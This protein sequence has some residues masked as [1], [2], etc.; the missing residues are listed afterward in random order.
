MAA[1]PGYQPR[2]RFCRDCLVEQERI[3]YFPASN[4]VYDEPFFVGRQV[5]LGKC[6][7]GKNTL[8]KID[9]ILDEGRFYFQPRILDGRDRIAELED[10][11][12]PSLI[13]SEHSLADNNHKDD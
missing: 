8:L 1:A 12:L 10:D 3:N 4:V 6:I 9:Y 11:S 2:S 7:A 5:F 13:H